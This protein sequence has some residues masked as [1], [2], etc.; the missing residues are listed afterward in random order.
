[1]IKK[2]I[3]GSQSKGPENFINKI[4]SDKNYNSLS[5]KQAQDLCKN[6][7]M[8]TIFDDEKYVNNFFK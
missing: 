2:Y 6:L 5:G 1:M 7:Q 3:A 4:Y 8:K